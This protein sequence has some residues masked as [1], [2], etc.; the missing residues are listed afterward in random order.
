M[1]RS[2]LTKRP[3]L[4]HPFHSFVIEN[5]SFVLRQQKRGLDI[6]DDD[7]MAD[8]DNEFFVSQSLS[9]SG[10]KDTSEEQAHLVEKGTGAQH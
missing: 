6:D 9:D 3:S 10:G 7:D 8:E 5:N 2:R 4:T 1:K